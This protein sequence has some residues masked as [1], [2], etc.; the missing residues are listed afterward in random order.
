LIANF[1]VR[2]LP[3][4]EHIKFPEVI[5]GAEAYIEAFWTLCSD[6]PMTMGGMGAIPFTSIDRYADRY[7][8]QD[9]PAFAMII[10]EL[11][12]AYLEVKNNG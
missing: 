1:K 11:D 2:G 4:P 8:F 12:E 7:G 10:R 5:S 3:V 6:R 9:F